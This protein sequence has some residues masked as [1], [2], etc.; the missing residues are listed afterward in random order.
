MVMVESTMLALG[1]QA[2]EFSLIDVVSGDTVTLENFSGSKALLVMFICVHCPFVKHVEQEL[3]QIGHD[4]AEQGLSIIAISANSIQTHPQDAPEHMKTQATTQGFNFPYC[5]DETQGVAKSYTAACTPDFFLFDG[6]L[7]L[8]YR[9]QLDDSRPSNGKPVTGKDLRQ[10]IDTLLA[11]Q[12]LSDD[13]IPSVG[14][15]IKWTPGQ[16]PAYF[17]A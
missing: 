1:T 17:G 14:C 13:Q 4:Y 15:N 6:A 11:G 9:G 16:A 10:A 8:A 5:Y 7:K 3:A 2:P 12:G